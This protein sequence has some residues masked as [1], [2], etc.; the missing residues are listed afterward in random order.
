M[1]V[2]SAIFTGEVNEVLLAQAVRVY[3]ANSRQGTAKVLARGEINRTKKKWFKQ[4]GTGNARHGARTPSIFVG[5]GVAHGPRG[6]QNHDLKLSAKMKKSAMLSALS[7]QKNQVSL[8]EKVM[9]VSGKTKE[10][11][12]LFD[13][14]LSQA[15]ILVIVDSLSPALVKS[16]NNLA[17][18]LLMNAKQVSLME[19]LHAD[20]IITTK[21]AVTV[22]EKRLLSDKTTVKPATKTAVKAETKVVTET[23]SPKQPAAK[24]AVA[25][26]AAKKAT[27]KP[28]AKKTT[29]GTK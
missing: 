24:K 11:A 23:K 2:S 22:L 20:K 27:A 7:L 19:I 8:D 26:P 21:A 28:A 10:A 4:K 5:G 13:K 25:K 3:R 9:S 12:A 18:V 14:K 17:N 6:N 15:R 29:K 16:F 1:S